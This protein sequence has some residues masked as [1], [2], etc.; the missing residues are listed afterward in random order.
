MILAI[1][2]EVTPLFL[3]LYLGLQIG[4]PDSFRTG[5]NSTNNFV[6]C[7]LLNK[8]YE[9]RFMPVEPSAEELEG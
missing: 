4:L 1:A 7:I 5:A 9:D 3:A 6:Y 8:T 2:P